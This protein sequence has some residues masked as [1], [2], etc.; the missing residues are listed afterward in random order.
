M[1]RARV[2]DDG[3]VVSANEALHFTLVEPVAS[4]SFTQG[5]KFQPEFT[6]QTFGQDE[7]IR[8]YKKLRVDIYLDSASFRPYVE[9][10][11]PADGHMLLQ[12]ALL[13]PPQPPG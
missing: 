3:R 12:S 8:G 4:G 13:E 11:C 10:R 9:L 1:K 6:H 5:A 2:S 7:E